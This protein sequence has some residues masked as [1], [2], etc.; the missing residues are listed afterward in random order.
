M[1]L[2]ELVELLR[3]S[4]ELLF[5]AMG[6]HPLVVSKTRAEWTQNTTVGFTYMSKSVVTDNAFGI[7]LCR[8]MLRSSLVS[9]PRSSRCLLSRC[10]W[11]LRASRRTASRW[12]LELLWTEM[13]ESSLDIRLLMPRKTPSWVQ[14]I[15]IRQIKSCCF[16]SWT[17]F[18]WNGTLMA[19]FCVFVFQNFHAKD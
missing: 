17:C 3:N 7:Y 19:A 16:I 18:K 12:M 14:I 8:S 10:I 4:P 1:F 11:V 6:G 2:T 15:I 5:H 13:E 9:W